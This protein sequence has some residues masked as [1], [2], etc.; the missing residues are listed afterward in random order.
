MLL[1]SSVDS[2]EAGSPKRCSS[3]ENLKAF[4]FGPVLGRG[5]AMRAAARKSLDS[6]CV[7]TPPSQG[8][9]GERNRR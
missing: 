2:G 1:S 9:V 4:G 8:M 3:E 5:E 7:G 6:D